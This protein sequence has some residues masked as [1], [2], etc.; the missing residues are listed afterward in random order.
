MPLLSRPLPSAFSVH[1]SGKTSFEGQTFDVHQF[2]R[3]RLLP[4]LRYLTQRS[5][6][7]P[8]L[9]IEVFFIKQPYLYLERRPAIFDKAHGFVL[10]LTRS[11]QVDHAFFIVLT[12]YT[13]TA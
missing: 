4:L 7:A 8:D 3:V 6:Y 10:Q 1:R 13:M 2:V 5:C 12:D 11:G 9:F